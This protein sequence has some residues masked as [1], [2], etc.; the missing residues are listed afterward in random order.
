MCMSANNVPPGQ[1]WNLFWTTA[2]IFRPIGIDSANQIRGDRFK[3]VKPK[4]P[5]RL[6]MRNFCDHRKE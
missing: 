6:R 4:R 2:Y 5:H 3:T 1:L